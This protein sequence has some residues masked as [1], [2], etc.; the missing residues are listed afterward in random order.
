MALPGI[1]VGAEF[2]SFA[3]LQEAVSLLE[4]STST[5]WRINRSD[6]LVESDATERQRVLYK[7]ATFVC[8]HFGAPRS[9]GEGKRQNQHYNAM[10]CEAT[11]RVIATRGAGRSST[12]AVDVPRKLVVMEANLEHKHAIS[13]EHAGFYPKRWCLSTGE[14][15][16][17][18]RLLQ[19]HVKPREVQKVLAESSGK[20]ILAR[21]IHWI[22]SSLD[23]LESGDK[24]EAEA[25][26]SK[27]SDFLEDDAEATVR[28]AMNDNN[29]LG[30][31]FFAT[32]EMTQNFVRFS[33]VLFMDGTYRIN[34]QHYVLIVFLVQDSHGFGQPAGLCFVRRE[35]DESV[36]KAVNA[37]YTTEFSTFS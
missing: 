13:E 32:K 1:E 21:Q 36:T 5:S 12:Q 15:E 27:V 4:K 18:A 16:E 25:L 20:N 34:V 37:Q 19:M 26:R 10:S 30:V 17:A 28:I 31:L 24:T 2:S 9:R 22:S 7:R 11:F 23:K 33:E 6:K 29:E 14:R 35:D 3:Q 8:T